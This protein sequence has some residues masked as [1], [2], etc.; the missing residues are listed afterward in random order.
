MSFA[1]ELTIAL[2][3][4]FIVG[5]LATFIGLGK[6]YGLFSEESH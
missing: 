1:Q 4:L 5:S 6:H 3:V 2:L